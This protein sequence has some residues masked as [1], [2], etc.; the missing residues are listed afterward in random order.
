MV[1]VIFVLLAIRNTRFM[2]SIIWLPLLTL[3]NFNQKELSKIFLNGS[4]FET[5]KIRFGFRLAF[6]FIDFEVFQNLQV[7][8]MFEQLCLYFCASFLI[9]GD[10]VITRSPSDPKQLVCKRVAALVS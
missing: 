4:R 5:A 2:V 9:R 8:C 6:N 3:S 1:L 10:V 7:S